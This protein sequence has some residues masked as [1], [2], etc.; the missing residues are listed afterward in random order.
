MDGRCQEKAYMFAQQA[1][2]ADFIDMITEPGIDG[3][4][5]GTHSVVSAEDIPGKISWIRAKAE[6]SAKGHGSKQCVIFGHCGCAGNQVTFEEHR[7]H[8][9]AALEKVR[10]WGLF[11]EV[12]AAAF[13]EDWTLE[14][15]RSA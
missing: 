8:L 10:G 7:A 4:L 3:L 11:D 5:S 2:G 14:E 9:L 1:S 6:I 15:V 12:R 13:T